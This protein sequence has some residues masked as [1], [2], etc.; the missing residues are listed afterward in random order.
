MHRDICGENILYDKDEN[1]NYYIKIIDWGLGGKLIKE[2]GYY[3]RDNV[4]KDGYQAPEILKNYKYDQ[5]VDIWSTGVLLFYF[6]ENK[7]PFIFEK[8][9]LN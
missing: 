4:G 8:E 5:K 7:L 3:L 6:L 1:D 9:E 2:E